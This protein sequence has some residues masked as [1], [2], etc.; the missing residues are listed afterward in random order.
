VRNFT[1]GFRQTMLVAGEILL[2]VIWLPCHLIR[3]LACRL[4]DRGDPWRQAERQ[5][6]P[7]S[8]RNE[9][10]VLLSPLQAKLDDL[11]RWE[12]IAEG[13]EQKEVHLQRVRIA[14]E[15]LK[16]VKSLLK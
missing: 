2:F 6:M 5:P 15:A 3:S 1:R 14:R 10:G 7:D 4:V 8:V 11:R 16:Q 13:D 9:V 12:V